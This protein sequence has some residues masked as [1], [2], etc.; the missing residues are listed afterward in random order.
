MLKQRP[1]FIFILIICTVCACNRQVYVAPTPTLPNPQTWQEAVSGTHNGPSST[2]EQDKDNQGAQ[3]KTEGNVQA[4]FSYTEANP[5]TDRTQI[6]AYLRAI[7]DKYLSMIT[8]PG[9]YTNPEHHQRVWVYIDDPQ[10]LHIQEMFFTLTPMNYS[11]PNGNLMV[12]NV[13]LQDG[14]NCGFSINEKRTDFDCTLINLFNKSS[15]TLKD[16]GDARELGKIHF[17]NYFLN[18]FIEIAFF[19]PPDQWEDNRQFSETLQAWFVQENGEPVL[20]VQHTSKGFGGL[21]CQECS[22]RSIG[23]VSTFKFNWNTGEFLSQKNSQ[24]YTDGSITEDELD[25][26]SLAL[27]KYQRYDSLPPEIEQLYLTAAQKTREAY[28]LKGIN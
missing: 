20:V 10:T 12:G 25:S 5:C 21:K 2:N 19:A 15:Y 24:E 9:W 23:S 11:S 4:D 17:D 8:E 26:A 1:I 3:Q 16:A 22:E 13:L 18:F 14:K 7:S 28:R 6:D 27:Y